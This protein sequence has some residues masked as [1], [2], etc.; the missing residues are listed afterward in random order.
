M[1]QFDILLL[2]L[3]REFDRKNRETQDG[4]AAAVV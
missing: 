2:L 1:F 4:F 3:S